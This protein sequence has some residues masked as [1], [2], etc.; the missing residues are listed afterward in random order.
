MLF[1]NLFDL[2][3]Q[4]I[5]VAVGREVR[6]VDLTAVSKRLFLE[7]DALIL[8]DEK[9]DELCHVVEIDKSLVKAN[10]SIA[11]CHHFQGVPQLDQA[12]LFLH[13]EA[14]VEE[15]LNYLNHF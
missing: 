11:F 9:V 15:A 6:L 2:L 10:T 3:N 8:I 12:H 13:V 4:K 1:F 5:H 7:N 14:H